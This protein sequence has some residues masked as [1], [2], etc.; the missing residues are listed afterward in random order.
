MKLRD[1]TLEQLADVICGNH[2]S[3]YG[4]PFPYRSGTQLC[5]FFRNL[6]IPGPYEGGTRKWWVKDVLV[7]LNEEEA[8]DPQAPSPSI[9]KVLEEVLDLRHFIDHE[10]QPLEGVDRLG[11]ADQLNQ[12]LIPEGLQL[13]EE[14]RGFQKLHLLDDGRIEPPPTVRDRPL[15]AAEQERR[16]RIERYLDAATEDQFTQEVLAPLFLKLNFERVNVAGHKEKILEFGV[17]LWM[18]FRL[19]T[20]HWIYF[21]V[22]V[23]TTKLGAGGKTNSNV[24]EVVN[25]ARMAFDAEIFD[26]E[27]NK[28]V[29]LDHLYII[30]SRGIT[31]Q[32]Q[33]LLVSKLDREARRH[34]IF[35]DREELLDRAAIIDSIL[36]TEADQDPW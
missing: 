7:R 26:P 11:A 18:K 25:Q 1:T 32:A 29:L 10:D 14:E 35:M 9:Q 33:Q 15:S 19:P 6:S 28:K 4:A 30:S 3:R 16:D 20:R 36:P 8:S 31:R 22:Q 5:T 2:E 17:D 12:L 24:M 21:A 27:L 23:K 34:I 13:I